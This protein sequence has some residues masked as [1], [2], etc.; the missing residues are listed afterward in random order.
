MQ[1]IKTTLE[2]MSSIDRELLGRS[3]LPALQKHFNDPENQ[4]RFKEW[5]KERSDDSDAD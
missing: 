5:L 1:P 2:E 3:L 4:R